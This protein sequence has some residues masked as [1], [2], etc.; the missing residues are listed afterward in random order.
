ME[1]R[2]SDFESV[3]SQGDRLI[4]QLTDQSEQETLCKQ[5]YDIANRFRRIQNLL[6]DRGGD[7]GT[8]N[9]S[10][11]EFYSALTDCNGRVEQLRASVREFQ[12]LASFREVDGRLQLQV[13]FQL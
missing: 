10:L 3:R 13:G 12:N 6:N 4:C 7:Y 5:M 11:Q 1:V 8:R 9:T 2:Q